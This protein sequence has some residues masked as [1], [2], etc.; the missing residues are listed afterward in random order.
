MKNIKY[1]YSFN[2]LFINIR[3]IKEKE[4]NGFIWH[5]ST[6]SLCHNHNN[7]LFTFMHNTLT[8]KEKKFI[9][10]M[11]RNGISNTKIAKI[12]SENTCKILSS[13]QIS[14][15]SKEEKRARKH[16]VMALYDRY[17]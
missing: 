9:L 3:K 8:D 17:K 1:V 7:D 11:M 15:F 14:V 2:D 6:Y 10:S 12:I 4:G 16:I 13:A 5:V